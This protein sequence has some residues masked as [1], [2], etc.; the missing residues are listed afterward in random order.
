MGAESLKAG[1]IPPHF[2]SY[3]MAKVKCRP[4]REG[5]PGPKPKPIGTKCK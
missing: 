1:A 5:K 2:R 4:E 3:A